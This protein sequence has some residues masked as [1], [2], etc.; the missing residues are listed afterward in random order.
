MI[1]D[2]E[3]FKR[4]VLKALGAPMIKINVTDEQLEDRV[5]EAVDLWHNFHYDGSV[6]TL[7]KQRVTASELYV[8]ETI[9]GEIPSGLHITGMESKATAITVIY[10]IGT[11]STNKVIL[12]KKIKGDFQPNEKIKVGNEVYQLI[13]SERCVKKGVYDE[14][15]IKI[16]PWI[17]G[18]TRIIPINQASSSQNL[19]DVQYQMRLSDLYDLTS[20]NLI[21]Y[22]QAMEHL[23]LLNFELTANPWFEY[24]RHDGYVYP[25]V[26][27]GYDIDVGDYMLMEV[28]RA[29]NPADIPAI[30][31]DTWLKRYAIALVKRQFAQNM[32]KYQNIQLAGGATL[33]ADAMYSE[34]QTDIE[35]LENELY[36]TLPPSAFFIG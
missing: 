7:L 1:R 3:D 36:S 8:K 20:T 4:Y 30:W 27:W 6:R 26:R 29:L 18:V 22:E 15:K 23:Q 2:R 24:N 32:K 10:S 5:D 13:D 14:G 31:N 21:Y 35:K 34:A 17:I 12:C 33:N 16:P 28:Y 19:F 25:I 9:K 11:Q